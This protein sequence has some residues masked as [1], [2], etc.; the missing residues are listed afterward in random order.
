M[1][2]TLV[3]SQLSVT[4]PKSIGVPATNC[5]DPLRWDLFKTIVVI[6]V[7]MELPEFSVN[8]FNLLFQTKNHLVWVWDEQIRMTRLDDW[9]ET[10]LSDLKRVSSECRQRP[11][12]AFNLTF[13]VYLKIIF[14]LRCSKNTTNITINHGSN[15]LSSSYL[16]K[17]RFER[18]EACLTWFL[19]WNFGYG[20]DL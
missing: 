3:Y 2:C 16:K 6:R 12:K 10:H 19:S 1:L 15:W 17:C 5:Y 11:S 20:H 18:K 4:T 9:F 13:M 14:L 7:W 8:L